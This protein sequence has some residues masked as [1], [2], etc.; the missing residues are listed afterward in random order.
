MITYTVILKFIGLVYIVI[1]LKNGHVTD[2][3]SL[4]NEVT[5]SIFIVNMAFHSKTT[6]FHIKN[7]AGFV[8][9]PIFCE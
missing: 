7:E 3:K 4:D 8:F 5:V 1:L 6:I 9:W 2:N